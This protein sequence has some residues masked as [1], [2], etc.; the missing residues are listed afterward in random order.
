M[1]DKVLRCRSCK[2]ELEN[3]LLQCTENVEDCN[4]NHQVWKC[5]KRKCKEN[6]VY[7]WNV[8]CKLRPDI[9]RG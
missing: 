9:R 3:K 1:E 2:K 8:C 7:N 6:I 5:K 4:I